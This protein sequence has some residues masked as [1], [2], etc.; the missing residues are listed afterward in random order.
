MEEKDKHQAHGMSVGKMKDLQYNQVHNPD[1]I[2]RIPGNNAGDKITDEYFRKDY[3]D[4][5]LPVHEKDFYHVV[6]EARAFASGGATAVRSSIPA[7][8]KLSRQAYAFQK[9][10][11]AFNG[12]IVHILHNPDLEVDKKQTKKEVQG[13]PVEELQLLTVDKL[14]EKFFELTGQNAQSAIKKNE[15]IGDILKAQKA[16]K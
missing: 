4:Y 7:V 14:K 8:H 11:K 16:K 15:L 10:H 6:A 5:T 12:Q 3:A 9:E 2:E 13:G 1:A